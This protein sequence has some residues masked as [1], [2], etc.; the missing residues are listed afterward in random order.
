[1]KSYEDDAL[2]KSYK[3]SKKRSLPSDRQLALDIV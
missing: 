3:T 1:M 2:N